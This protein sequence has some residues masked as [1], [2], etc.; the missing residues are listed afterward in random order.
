L[1]NAADLWELAATSVIRDLAARAGR[2]KLGD[3]LPLPFDAALEV[4]PAPFGLDDPVWPG[5]DGHLPA[6]R[7]ILSTYDGVW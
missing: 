4:G 5:V 2:H 1:C 3:L 7:I 6:G